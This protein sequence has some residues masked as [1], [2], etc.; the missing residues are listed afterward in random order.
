MKRSRSDGEATGLNKR[1]R[2]VKALRSMSSAEDETFGEY[3]IERYERGLKKAIER[4]AKWGEGDRVGERGRELATLMRDTVRWHRDQY[5]ERLIEFDGLNGSASRARSEEHVN[6]TKELFGIVLDRGDE[7]VRT[8][9]DATRVVERPPFEDCLLEEFE[10]L[11][12]ELN[13]IR[14]TRYRTF[15]SERMRGLLR[16]C[17]FEGATAR[18]CERMTFWE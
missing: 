16:V 15:D 17:R 10:R 8:L 5:G 9:C 13:E 4:L 18:W 3:E 14:D 7:I 1:R 6:A 12:E 2:V 11:T